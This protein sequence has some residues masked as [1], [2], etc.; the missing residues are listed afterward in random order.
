MIRL[1]GCEV[2]SRQ[3]DGDC[4]WGVKVWD[5]KQRTSCVGEASG[6][7]PV[8][9]GSW[10]AM[11]S[12]VPRWPRSRS[13]ERTKDEWKTTGSGS[14]TMLT[15]RCWAVV[16]NIQYGRSAAASWP[17]RRALRRCVCVCVFSVFSLVLLLSC[18]LS[19]LSFPRTHHI[20]MMKI[21]FNSL[22]HP[23]NF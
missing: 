16:V 18:D 3:A 23:V 13:L 21:G 5:W 9:S 22:S 20:N 19:Y 6:Q 2:W 7:Q 8:E 12:S 10:L 14:R 15:S 11:L 17:G 4:S 1:G